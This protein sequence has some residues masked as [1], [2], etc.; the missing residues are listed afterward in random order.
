MAALVTVG[1]SVVLPM[2]SGATPAFADPA[3]SVSKT[4]AGAF[5]KGETGTWN[6]FVRNVGTDP[7]VGPI[8]LTDVFPEGSHLDFINS[9]AG[10]ECTN[11]PT[12]ESVTCTYLNPVAPGEVLGPLLF[13]VLIEEDAPCTL[14]NTVTVSGGGSSLGTATDPTPVTGGDCTPADG[15]GDGGSILP[16]NLNGVFTMFNNINTNNNIGSPGA[17]NNAN[18]SAE[19]TAP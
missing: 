13:G 5:V 17:S 16:I 7:T 12:G 9:P 3:L 4:H 10:W 18:Q 14:T 15:D 8:T 1:T 6:I 11:P 2:S 19:V